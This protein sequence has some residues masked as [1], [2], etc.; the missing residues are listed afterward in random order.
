MVGM[1]NIQD[2]I[3]ACTCCDSRGK[4]TKRPLICSLF[5][6][7]ALSLTCPFQNEELGVITGCSGQTFMLSYLILQR[8]ADPAVQGLQQRSPPLQPLLRQ[9]AHHSQGQ[10][11]FHVPPHNMRHWHIAPAVV[12]VLQPN[13]K[14]SAFTLNAAL[15][16]GGCLARAPAHL[17]RVC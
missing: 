12:Y 11:M 17:P 8:Q 4:A 14:L 7:K 10:A 13:I 16:F 5:G 6:C 2:A 9:M 15:E 3:T 1:D